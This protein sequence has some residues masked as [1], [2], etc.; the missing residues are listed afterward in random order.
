MK[1]RAGSVINKVEES[2]ARL[3]TTTKKEDKLPVSG[4][5]WEITTDPADIKEVIENTTN[6]STQY[7]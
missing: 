7:I 6:T 5:K 4:M 2:L 3:T 1:Q